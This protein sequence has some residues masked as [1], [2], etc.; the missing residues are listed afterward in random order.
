MNSISPAACRLHRRSSCYSTS[1]SCI[2]PVCSQPLRPARQVHTGLP[3]QWWYSCAWVGIIENFVCK[4]FRVLPCHARL[5]RLL[6]Y[7]MQAPCGC[8]PQHYDKPLVKFSWGICIH[9]RR[10]VVGGTRAALFDVRLSSALSVVSKM[11]VA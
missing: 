6:W 4:T 7:C 1:C 3:F 10:G 5:R 9:H 8:S 2:T 11:V